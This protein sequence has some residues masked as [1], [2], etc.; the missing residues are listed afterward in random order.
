MSPLESS[1][2]SDTHALFLTGFRVVSLYPFESLAKKEIE[3]FNDHFTRVHI[4]E[5]IKNQNHV[6]LTD[7]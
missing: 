1:A 2:I 4:T 6:D 5:M 7:N 3:G